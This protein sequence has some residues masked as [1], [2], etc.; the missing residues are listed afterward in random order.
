MNQSRS[1]RSPKKTSDDIHIT[2]PGHP[3]V[4]IGDA[5]LVTPGLQKGVFANTDIKKGEVVFIAK[6]RKVHLVIRSRR[7]S[8]KYPNG[9]GLKKHWWL[10]PSN[11]NPLKYLNHSCEPNAGV[12]GSVTIVARKNIKEGEHITIDYSTTEC[13][14]FWDLDDDCKCGA[15]NCRKVICSIQSLPVR[16]YR[17]YLPYIPTYF[18][19]V[20]VNTHPHLK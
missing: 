10:N 11:T 9:L 3:K 1:K 18:Q 8:M 6:G 2:L 15:K 19:K 13:D 5:D 16:I 17:K 12:K 4:Y 20:Y 7:D 14:P